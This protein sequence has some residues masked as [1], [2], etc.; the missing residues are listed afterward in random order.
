[1]SGVR[2]PYEAK[3]F[4]DHLDE[5]LQRAKDSFLRPDV[6]EDIVELELRRSRLESVLYRV[7]LF[8]QFFQ[9]TPTV[10]EMV[11]LSMNPR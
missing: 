4:A 2:A 11:L 10:R 1:M 9:L 7:Y 6:R 8:S 5:L 3:Y